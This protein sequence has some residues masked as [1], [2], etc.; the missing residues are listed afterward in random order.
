[1]QSSGSQKVFLPEA[2]SSIQGMEVI[3][4][5]EVMAENAKWSTAGPVQP[6]PYP[7]V[8]VHGG[9]EEVNRAASGT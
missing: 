3:M 2:A 1:M 7:F 9:T 4:G 6:G 5:I 8:A